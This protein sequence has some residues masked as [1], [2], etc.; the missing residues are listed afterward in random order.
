MSKIVKFID[1]GH[2][3]GFLG[4]LKFKM[5]N[6]IKFEDETSIERAIKNYIV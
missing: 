2:L 1:N 4:T 3:E 5:F 6:G